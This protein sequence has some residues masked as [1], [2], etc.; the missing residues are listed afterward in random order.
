MSPAIS[1]V[2]MLTEE[3]I[4]KEKVL[5]VNVLWRSARDSAQEF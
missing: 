1:Q 2:N 3:S 5:H 4:R